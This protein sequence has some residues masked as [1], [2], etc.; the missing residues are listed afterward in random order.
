[1]LGDIVISIEYH[2]KL[3]Q[4]SRTLSFKR[5]SRFRPSFSFASS[6]L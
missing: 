4:E 1:M 6:W 3:K 5:K 2:G